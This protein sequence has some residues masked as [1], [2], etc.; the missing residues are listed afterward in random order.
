MQKQ[1]EQQ[2]QELNLALAEALANLG[3]GFLVLDRELVIVFVNWA[4]AQLLQRRREDEL[5]GRKFLEAFPPAHG[6]IL[7][8]EFRLALARQLPVSFETNLVYLPGQSSCEVRVYP[9]RQ[10]I[11]VLF[12]NAVAEKHAEA[13]LHESEERYHSL[14]D[15]SLDAIL[16]IGPDGKILGANPATRTLFGYTEVDL[17][18]MPV[19][20]ILYTSDAHFATAIQVLAHTSRFRGEL[21]FVRKNGTHFSAEVATA[22]FKDYGGRDLTS[23]IIRD[24]TERKQME[25]VW[26]REKERLALTLDSLGDGMITTDVDEKIILFNTMAALLTGWRESEALGQP[27]PTVLNLIH[28]WTR[29]PIPDLVREAIEKGMVC[30]LPADTVL[31]ARDGAERFISS[32]IAPIREQGGTITG[33]A[34]VF[35]DITRLK[36]AENALQESQAYTR[37]L[38]DS[39]LDMIIAVDCEGRIIE[40]NR[41]AQ[42]TFGFV[43]DEIIGQEASRLYA[44]GEI[45][46]QIHAQTLKNGRCVQET[47]SRRKDGQVF[48]VLIASSL[49]K[50]PNGEVFGVMGVWRDITQLKQAEAQN[51]KSARMAALGRMAAALAHEV[52][53]PLQAIQSTLDLV[54]DFNIEPAERE[55]NLRIIRQEIARLIEITTQILNFARP[56]RAPRQSVFV[57]DLLRDT[58]KLARKQLQRAQVQVTTDFQPVPAIQAAPEQLSQVFLNLILNSIEA[59]ETHGHLHV[60]TFVQ[61]ETATITFTNDGP[62]IPAPDLPRLFEPF[63]TTKSEGSGI[64]LSISQNLVQQHGGTITAE[65]LPR[66]VVFTVQLPLARVEEGEAQAAK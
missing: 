12:Q 47:L 46:L 28:L 9:I 32:S 60:A 34:L 45:G 57:D 10:G 48:P 16:I 63:F 19:Q 2:P 8:D 44:D 41:A 4:A 23:M 20:Q 40:F 25:A 13:S 5:R 17:T 14:F 56:S 29:Q 37:S 21:V 61:D 22:V 27:L 15:H 42:E 43:R 53:N 11:A 35:R 31:L 38:I 51:L 1:A 30:G 7:E 65:N 18:H 58:L 66:G 50:A 24:V 49:L 55:D 26:A 3:A 54:L 64:G 62:N 33:A 36:R 6:S 59:M 52:N 39:S